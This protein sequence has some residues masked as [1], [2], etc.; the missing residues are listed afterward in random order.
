MFSDLTTGNGDRA[1]SDSA[2]GAVFITDRGTTESTGTRKTEFEFGDEEGLSE[3]SGKASGMTVEQSRPAPDDDTQ[4]L[5][6]SS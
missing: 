4:Q 3:R 6:G 5:F 1:V 2:G